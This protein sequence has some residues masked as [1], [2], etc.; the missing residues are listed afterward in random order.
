M[1]RRAVALAVAA[2]VI[3]ILLLAWSG[4]W[5]GGA[6]YTSTPG[7]A[8]AAPGSNGWSWNVVDGRL[9]VLF[10]GSVVAELAPAQLLRVLYSG[11][12]VNFTG[13][14]GYDYCQVE[15]NRAA[16]PYQDIYMFRHRG[17][18]G[19]LVLQ[20]KALDVVKA[21]EP[22]G[23]LPTLNATPFTLD[24]EV[25]T[26]E[27]WAR[28]RD[29][30]ASDPAVK[31]YV[32]WLRNALAPDPSEALNVPW[33]PSYRYWWFDDREV[34]GAEPPGNDTV[35]RIGVVKL[36][37]GAGLVVT[38]YQ[39]GNH[40][41][42]VVH[43]TIINETEWREAVIRAALMDF[44][45]SSMCLV[46]YTEY[47]W[48][49]WRIIVKGYGSHLLVGDRAVPI[50]NVYVLLE[51]P[52]VK[53]GDIFGFMLVDKAYELVS[54][55]L[56]GR[57]A[58]S[59]A[60]RLAY[61]EG[62]DLVKLYPGLVKAFTDSVVLTGAVYRYLGGYATL[63]ELRTKDG[64]C[65]DFATATIDFA[66]LVFDGITM[67]WS[68]GGHA[69]SLL[70]IPSSVFGTDAGPVPVPA[71]LD[72]DGRNES[73]IVLADT[74]QYSIDEISSLIR[75]L[76][77][78][79]SETDI[80]YYKIYTGRYLL[81]P[82]GATYRGVVLT[83]DFVGLWQAAE[84]LPAWLQPSWH[85]TLGELY[86]KMLVDHEGRRPLSLNDTN[87]EDKARANELWLQRVE[88]YYR[89]PEVVEAVSAIPLVKLSPPSKGLALNSTLSEMPVVLSLHT[90][91]INLEMLNPSTSGDTEAEEGSGGQLRPVTST[92][93]VTA[94]VVLSP[95]H[96]NFSDPYLG[97][98]LVF[99]RFTG[100]VF[101]NGTNITVVADPY[102]RDEY[103]VK[104]LVNGSW[105]Y[106]LTTDLPG[107]VA[108]SHDGVQ[109]VLRLET[110]E[111]PTLNLTL[112]PR[113]EPF[114]TVSLPAPDGTL[115][116][117]ALYMVNET[118]RAGNVTVF[119]T[120]SVSRLGLDLYVYVF[121]VPSRNY[122][123]SVTGLTMN[124][125]EI[126][127][128]GALGIRLHYEAPE[129][130]GYP[131]LIPEGAVVEITVQPLNLTITVPVKG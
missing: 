72:G 29:Y 12:T 55:R 68:D 39:Y 14:L 1:N 70:I 128:A 129:S 45:S 122:T 31:P 71:D 73:A 123:V 51:L 67:F 61:S 118:V 41:D 48:A 60:V 9:V 114:N 92:P 84:E 19:Y 25:L 16:L 28:M 11:E 4:P 27:L 80:G 36:P 43:G 30:N 78:V 100:M 106:S 101:V 95:V 109:Y 13:V 112:E 83:D 58:L 22:R 35:V 121:G 40:I 91:P 120:G 113:L 26:H 8:P 86:D 105:A 2:A 63:F 65:G 64:V 108:F 111:P 59:L 6:V 107:T 49:L 76:T 62:A 53:I 46:N 47:G 3:L 77:G 79:E 56:I 97:P 54:W 10:N 98:I 18:S 66:T 34:W 89:Y 20:V 103:R 82:G 21:M 24:G 85:Q 104:I 32:E 131:Q 99:D 124:R 37:F 93:T 96:K 15:A 127:Y 116:N 57:P 115:V 119:I 94:T 5:G 130:N 23:R 87:V 50:E 110:P 75:R 126:E 52:I 125:T 69:I 33:Y 38:A 74:A 90:P 17:E 44:I 42:V 102:G 7:L 81:V 117:F 88:L